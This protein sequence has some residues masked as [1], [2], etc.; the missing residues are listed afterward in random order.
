MSGVLDSELVGRE[1]EREALDGA[2]AA[3]AVG[4][5]GVVVLAGEAGIG[6]TRLLDAARRGLDDF[7]TDGRPA[8]A[9]VRQRTGWTVAGKMASSTP[10]AAAT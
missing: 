10:I 9:G 7:P 2:L 6:K 1:R 3:A 4:R 5:S 8:Q